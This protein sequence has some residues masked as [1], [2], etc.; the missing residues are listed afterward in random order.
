[1][2][3]AVGIAA[4]LKSKTMIG[5]YVVLALLAGALLYGVLTGEFVET[6]KN[7]ATL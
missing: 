2:N 7:G 5:R 6:W 4:I 1:M 3:K